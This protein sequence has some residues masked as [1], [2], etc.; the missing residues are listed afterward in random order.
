MMTDRLFHYGAHK[1]VQIQA[2]FSPTYCYFFRMVTHNILPFHK[3][4]VPHDKKVKKSKKSKSTKGRG[5][6]DIPE[7]S[8]K[9]L[10]IAHG[11]DVSRKIC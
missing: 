9:F 3:G 5:K 1:A 4:V 7:L 2:K 10:G 6:R 11:D 8:D